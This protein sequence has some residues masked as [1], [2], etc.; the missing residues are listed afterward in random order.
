[1]SYHLKDWGTEMFEID[2]FWVIVVY[3]KINVHIALEFV[4]IPGF[5]ETDIDD[6]INKTNK[7]KS[8]KARDKSRSYSDGERP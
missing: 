5:K 2:P 6:L 1:M 8:S 4:A 7:R 3:K